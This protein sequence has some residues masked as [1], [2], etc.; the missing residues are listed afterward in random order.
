MVI[1]GRLDLLYDLKGHDDLC[2]LFD[3]VYDP[4]MSLVIRGSRELLYDPEGHGDLCC[5][6]DLIFDPKR[7]QGH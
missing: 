1:R 4:K 2:G 6:L 7:S 3:L 5:R